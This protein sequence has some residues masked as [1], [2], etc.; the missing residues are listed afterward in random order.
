MPLP[1]LRESKALLDS[2]FHA[3][4]SG[5]HVLYMFLL[6]ELVIWIPIVGGILQEQERFSLIPNSTGN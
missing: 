6:M 2:G 5:F 4:D 1:L 3:L